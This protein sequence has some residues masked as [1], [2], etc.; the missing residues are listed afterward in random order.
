MYK[1]FLED[2]NSLHLSETMPI[3]GGDGVAKVGSTSQLEIFPFLVLFSCW[4]STPPLLRT[5][6]ENSTLTG[7][8][9]AY[10]TGN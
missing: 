8:T 5:H 2:S 7:L 10:E 3:R 1:V 4:V 6:A 9:A